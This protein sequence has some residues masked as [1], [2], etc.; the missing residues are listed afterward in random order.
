M[1]SLCRDSSMCGKTFVVSV[2]NSIFAL[3]VE[4]STIKPHGGDC[5]SMV[6]SVK[7]SMES[8]HELR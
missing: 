5:P 7:R 4:T 2:L 3:H 1:Y 6:V 8:H